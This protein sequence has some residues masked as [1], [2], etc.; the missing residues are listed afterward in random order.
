MVHAHKPVRGFLT[1]LAIA[2]VAVTLRAAENAPAPVSF[3]K[4][5]APILLEQCQKCH[6]PEKSKGGYRLDSFARLT[7]PGESKSPSLT[8]GTPEQ[9]ELY[10]LL[11]APDEEDRMPKKSDPL[12]KAQIQL[13][14]RWVEQGAKFDGPDPAAAL[15]MIVTEPEQ[16]AAPAVYQ[17]PVPVTALAFS[18]D[19]QELAVGGYHEITFWDPS[20]GK[21]LARIPKLPQR[22]H[23]LAYAPDGRRLAAASGTPGTLGE[24]RLFDPVAHNAGRVLDRGT[25]VMLAARFSFDGARLAAGGADNAVRIYSVESGRRER[26]I[27]QHSDWVTDVAF[28]PDGTKLVSASR[29]KSARVFDVKTGSMLAA[30]LAH[31]EPVFG[32]TFGSDGKLIYSA[33]RDRRIRVW[34]AADAKP[35]GEVTGFEGEPF[36]LEL[37]SGM[38]FSACADGIVRQF[39]EE[40]RELVRA[41]PK[42]SDW[43]Y[44]LS[45]DVNHHR[46]AAGSYGGEVR[47]Y[48]TESGALLN[49]FFA[50]PG[51]VAKRN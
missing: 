21:L 22:I 32:V 38:L 4:D 8:P 5:V 25:D 29:D 50:A 15:S 48:D 51:Y 39:K 20:D 16:P 19:G 9:S 41:Y 27:E 12:P 3:V 17:R 30:F 14:K 34:K 35:A 26:V 33:G 43:V 10:R 24:V 1:V 40:N 7:R 2:W 18:P 47:T 37:S 44:C 36:R 45:I 13:I 28:S 31:E 42:A 11:T 23:G 6:G 49:T 46:L